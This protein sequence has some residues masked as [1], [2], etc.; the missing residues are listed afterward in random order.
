MRRP[1]VALLRLLA[2]LPGAALL[3]V[4]AW[5]ACPPDLADGRVIAGA[6]GTVRLAWRVEGIE[7]AAGAAP[8]GIPAAAPPPTGRPFLLAVTVCPDTA[9]L[10][11]VDAV[12]PE[13]R[14][15]MNYAPGIE[16]AGPGRF[17]VEGMLLHM[18]GRW[19]F[20]FDVEAGGRTERLAEALVVR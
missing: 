4:A 18:A 12:M 7:P 9:R 19:E 11:R 16:P 15:G 10:V 1:A 17:R 14:H 3:P 2:L 20:R 5:A 6:D 8:A 13:H